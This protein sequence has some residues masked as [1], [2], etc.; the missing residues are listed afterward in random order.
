VVRK[1]SQ[2][3]IFLYKKKCKMS[4][5]G[6]NIEVSLL[7][8]TLSPWCNSFFLSLSLSL[9][10]THTHTHSISPPLYLEFSGPLFKG[11]DGGG[12]GLKCRLCTT[13]CKGVSFKFIIIVLQILLHTFKTLFLLS[14]HNVTSTLSH[15][16]RNA[17]IQWSQQ[18]QIFNQYVRGIKILVELL[19]WPFFSFKNVKI[20]PLVLFSLNLVLIL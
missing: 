7:F 5:A 6:K 2:L 8:A 14:H 11:K 9:S 3:I 4:L 20:G 17:S 12:V 1:S 13:I 10:L 15:K 18:P 16:P 19:F